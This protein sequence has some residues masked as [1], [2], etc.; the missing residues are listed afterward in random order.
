MRRRRPRPRARL[1]RVSTALV[2]AGG[3]VAGIA[4]EL[5]VLRGLADAEPALTDRILA[6]DVVVGTSAGASVAAQITSGVPLDDLYQAQ[7]R[8]GSAEIEVEIDTDVLLADLAAAMAG[9][10]TPEEAR[11]RVGR[12]ALAADTVHPSVRL[13]AVDARLPVKRWPDRRLL[14]TAV[15]AD[16]GER[17]VLTRDSGATLLDAVAASAAVPGVWPVVTVG[18]RRL[19]D[20]GAWSAANADLAA[21]AA[22]VLIIRPV[23]AATPEPW[24]N[25][26][27]EIETLAP[28][29]VHVIDADPASIEA[30]GA[31][32]LSPATRG[33][34]AREGRRVG[35]A[36]ADHVAALWP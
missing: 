25:L 26:T 20:G 27:E 18:D 1:G 7:L 35:A 14:V 11:R 19:M 29:A 5:G 16:T 2:L 6:A 34:A 28:A 32:A 22:H 24:G 23:L 30:F 4:W 17:V 13:A 3:G 10:A 31:N 12:L 33:P 21:G 15:D 9:A 8:P 36:H